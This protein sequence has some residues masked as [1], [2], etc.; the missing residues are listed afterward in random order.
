MSHMLAIS[1]LSSG[2]SKD[3]CTS[4]WEIIMIIPL[5]IFIYFNNTHHFTRRHGV[6]VLKGGRVPP[7]V[8]LSV[9]KRGHGQRKRFSSCSRRRKA[10]GR[11][12]DRGKGSYREVDK[13]GKISP[14][15]SQQQQK[16]ISPTVVA[17]RC[18]TSPPRVVAAPSP[19]THPP[20]PTDPRA[21]PNRKGI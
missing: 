2:I 10:N 19:S 9:M 17:L 11:A 12:L 13:N 6:E 8:S 16:K 5:K 20:R 4:Q 18:T 1:V 7:A 3:M 21:R 14:A 15:H